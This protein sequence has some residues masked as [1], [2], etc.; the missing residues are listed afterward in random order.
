MEYANFE[1]VTHIFPILKYKQLDPYWSL[2]ADVPSGDKT[3]FGMSKRAIKYAD[4]ERSKPFINCNKMERRQ[5]D[6]MRVV[7]SQSPFG[8]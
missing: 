1:S 8:E 3:I 2:Q 5:M 6:P 4:F 7:L